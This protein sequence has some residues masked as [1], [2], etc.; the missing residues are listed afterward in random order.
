MSIYKG[1]K[2]LFYILLISAG[3]T[4][5][6]KYF[7]SAPICIVINEISFKLHRQIA[8]L[9]V[10]DYTRAEYLCCFFKVTPNV[11]ASLLP[12]SRILAPTFRWKNKYLNIPLLQVIWKNEKGLN[13][14]EYCLK[15]KVLQWC[16]GFFCENWQKLSMPTMIKYHTYLIK[17]NYRKAWHSKLKFFFKHHFKKKSIKDQSIPFLTSAGHLFFKTEIIEYLKDHKSYI[18][19]KNL[20]PA[21]R[22]M[23]S[24]PECALLMLLLPFSVML[25]YF[26]HVLIATK[27]CS[28][29]HQ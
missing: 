25:S 20:V 18:D 12:G 28:R 23:P 19:L 21:L 17:N 16:F 2:H 15:K 10:L 7:W 1:Y 4:V 8:W 11:L 3:R 6:P 29:W 27:E 22:R 24:H 9:I 13:K 14:Q 26:R 5:H